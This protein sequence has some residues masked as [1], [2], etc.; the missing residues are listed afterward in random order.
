MAILV[1]VCTAIVFKIIFFKNS[2]FPFLAAGGGGG[3]VLEFY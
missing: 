2:P 1:V 3:G